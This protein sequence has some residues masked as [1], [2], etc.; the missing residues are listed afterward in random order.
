[1]ITKE[2]AELLI[3]EIGNIPLA[4]AT[5]ADHITWHAQ[6]VINKI[7]QCIR[8]LDDE[9]RLLKDLRL[10]VADIQKNEESLKKLWGY[11]HNFTAGAYR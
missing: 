3:K 2:Q 9:P 1:M 6:D 4:A 7:N 11:F 10:M 8:P 5:Y